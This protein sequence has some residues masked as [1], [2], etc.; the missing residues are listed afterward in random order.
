MC[1]KKI[2]YIAGP[3][4]GVP[5]YKTRFCA[6]E[7][8]LCLKGYRVINP[9]KLPEGLTNKQYMHVCL[10]LIDC[11][12]VVLFMEGSQDSKGAMSEF[13]YCRCVGKP[14]VFKTEELDY[15]EKFERRTNP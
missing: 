13:A 11:A 9:A 5:D 14:H 6:V 1:K 15:L 8:E 4:T 12:D 7:T 10:P 2:V 3:I